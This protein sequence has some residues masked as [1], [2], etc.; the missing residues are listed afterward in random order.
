[1]FRP[2]LLVVKVSLGFVDALV[3]R[4]VKDMEEG[5]VEAELATIVQ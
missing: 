3:V 2:L 4:S 1:M 5:F